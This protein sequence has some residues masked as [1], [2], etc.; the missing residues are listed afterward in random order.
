MIFTKEDRIWARIQTITSETQMPRITQNATLHLGARIIAAILVGASVLL[1]PRA[2]AQDEGPRFTLIADLS[3]HDRSIACAAFSP[4]VKLV[5]TTSIDETVRISDWVAGKTL[6]TLEGF[7]PG[8]EGTWDRQVVFL[9]DGKRLLTANSASSLELWDWKS[10]TQIWKQAV[11]ARS[12]ALSP[13]ETRL[14]TADWE[15][16]QLL[17]WETSSGKQLRELTGIG[18]PMKSGGW[19]QGTVAYAPSG[20]LFASTLGGTRDDSAPDVILKLWNAETQSAVAE[21]VPTIKRIHALTWSPDGTLLVGGGTEGTLFTAKLPEVAAP[22]KGVV[23]LETLIEQLDAEDFA[24]RETA[25][26]ELQARARLVNRELESLLKK[27]LPA[28]VRL[29]ITEVLKKV[30]RIAPEV[31]FLP[32]EHP[33]TIMGV[34]FSPDGRLLAS[35]SRVHKQIKGRLVIWNLS[36]IKMPIFSWDGP[37]LTSVSFSPDGKHL[38]TSGQDGRVRIWDVAIGKRP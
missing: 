31:S 23:K 19:S 24:T 17:V 4:D 37:G 9:K 33:G 3:L 1:A 21:M 27:N 6:V 25:Q 12:L 11:G 13:D 18:A 16:A 36:D 7:S 32:P 28:E 29:R 2:E 38:L 26:K 5:A 20:K 34:A 8:E 22:A 14:V 15:H 30:D 10:K 35:V